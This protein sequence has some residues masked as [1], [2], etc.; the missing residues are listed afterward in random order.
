MHTLSVKSALKSLTH[1][2]LAMR[3][4]LVLMAWLTSPSARADYDPRLKFYTLETARFRFHYQ[5]GYEAMAREAAQKGEASLTVVESL[6]GQKV[7][8]KIDIVLSDD[9]DDA[10]GSA[11]VMPYPVVRL[12]AVAPD[13][14]SILAEYDDWILQ[15]IGHELTHIVHLST[16]GGL[17]KAFNLIFGQ[18]MMPNQLQSRW[19]IEGLAVE[20]ESR[21][22]AGGR[23][24]ADMVDMVLR[25]E[26]VD[27]RL[28]RLDQ[29]LNGPLQWPQGNAFYLHGG[30]FLTWLSAHYGPDVLKRVSQH[31]AAAP[32]P[33]AM[34][35]SMIAVTGRGYDELWRDFQSDLAKEYG[36]QL[37]PITQRREGRP[38]TRRGQYNEGARYLSDGRIFYFNR[39]LHSL[40]AARLISADRSEDEN[41]SQI[42]SGAVT[43]RPFAD[44]HAVMS[45]SEV[46]RNFYNY[47]D[48]FDYDLS[49]K[50]YRRLTHGLRAREPEVSA[51]GS[52]VYFIQNRTGH[53]RLMRAA[54]VRDHEGERVLSA[55]QVVWEMMPTKSASE[56]QMYTPRLSPDGRW[57]ALSV[58]RP[59]GQR[60]LALLH[61]DPVSGQVLEVSWLTNDSALDGNPVFS[62]GGETLYFHSARG[63]IYNIYAM[64]LAT[65]TVKQVTNV[66]TGAFAPDISPDGKRMVYQHYSAN[67]FDLYEMDLQPEQFLTPVQSPEFTTQDIARPQT[68]EWPW[69]RD[70]A[71]GVSLGKV[72]PYTPPAVT[73]L[74]R[75]WLPFLSQDALGMVVGITTSGI[76][77]LGRH[78][79]ALQAG[80]GIGSQDLQYSI[81]YSNRQLYP[82]LNVST[83]RYIQRAL[84]D[85]EIA[86]QRIATYERLHEVSLEMTVP[87]ARALWRM[88]GSFEYHFE[89]HQLINQFAAA[90]G[91]STLKLPPQGH[92]SGFSARFNINNLRRTAAAISP[93][94]GQALSL[95]GYLDDTWSGS[96][97]RRYSLAASAAHY[98]LMPYLSHHVLMVRGAFGTSFNQLDD[99][100]VYGLGGLQVSDFVKDFLF[101]RPARQGLLR[102]FG[103]NTFVGTHYYALSAEYRAPLWRIE[104]GF[105]V[106]PFYF[107]T[108]HAAAFVDVGHASDGPSLFE[109]AAVG[110]GGELRLDMSYGFYYGATLRLGYARGVTEG[111]INNF[112][113]TLGSGF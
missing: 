55:P 16:M 86:G 100:P 96:S 30:R 108:L 104:R 38:L 9:T 85:A 51:D 65:R 19:F 82:L 10:N 69:Q 70:V 67:G 61:I 109:R 3:V 87:Y 29:A 23:V 11:T 89:H 45:Q 95:S 1:P 59:P 26:F 84:Q 111:G 106:F 20:V 73:L 94:Y 33:Y 47:Q 53:S 15:L 6:L 68:A 44:G 22:S 78:A 66:L 90:P 52:Y 42:T 5:A 37:A 13:N 32:I 4:L 63:H 35:R 97:F 7:R 101:Q 56:W 18:I 92:Y 40:P 80:Y 21:L 41:L 25:S 14:L 91:A 64:D 107:R 50:S 81:G 83:S 102:G 88:S 79:W 57:I 113:L 98:Q 99:R 2:F 27:N 112:F 60:D 105:S 8:T 72:K 28:T 17:P 62:P 93:E 49:G 36:A 74:P 39:A 58:H 77:P 110:I 76:D 71:A 46:S 12:F 34:N 43:A 103:Q 31:Y 48:L 54:M 75:Y 24:H